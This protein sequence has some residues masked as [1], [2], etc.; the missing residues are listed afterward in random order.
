MNGPNFRTK[1]GFVGLAIL[2]NDSVLDQT[3]NLIDYGRKG[4]L[5][6]FLV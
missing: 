3:M 5:V 6:L 2:V 1:E 4:N